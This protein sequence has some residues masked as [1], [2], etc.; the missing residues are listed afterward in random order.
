MAAWGNPFCKEESHCELVAKGG[1]FT[2]NAFSLRFHV[3]KGKKPSESPPSMEQPLF[4][5]ALN[6][7]SLTINKWYLSGRRVGEGQ[8]DWGAHEGQGCWEVAK[9]LVLSKKHPFPKPCLCSGMKVRLWV[10]CHNRDRRVCASSG[11]LLWALLSAS[12]EPIIS[13]HCHSNTSHAP[14]HCLV[15]QPCVVAQ[16][17]HHLAGQGPESQFCWYQP[18]YSLLTHW[19]LPSS[20]YFR[21]NY[22]PPE[23]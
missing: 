2:G 13:F 1:H 14:Y 18:A 21:F 16:R 4:L 23:M 6:F 19:V 8:K 10:L 3:G 9:S 17:C 15:S 7:L 22:L 5:K 12:P 11:A 20:F